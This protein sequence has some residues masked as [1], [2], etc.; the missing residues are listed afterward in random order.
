MEAFGLL[1]RMEKLQSKNGMHL[2]IGHAIN[3]HYLVSYAAPA[4]RN[5]FMQICPNAHMMNNI[6]EHMCRSK[7]A[8][9]TIKEN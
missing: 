4:N 7:D 1:L 3:P 8:K 5:A 2:I 9:Q 6:V